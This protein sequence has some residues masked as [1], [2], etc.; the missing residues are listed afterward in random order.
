MIDLGAIRRAVD[1]DAPAHGNIR[2]PIHDDRRPSLSLAL[3]GDGRLLVHCKSGCE[4][5]AVFDAVR[6][7][8][9]HLL[10]GTARMGSGR[11]AETAYTYKDAKGNPLARVIRKDSPDGSKTFR[12]QT[13]DGNG[14]W[15]WKGPQGATP[16]FGLDR[17][18]R[19]TDAIVVLCEGEKSAEAAQRRLG[20]GF[21][22]MSWMGG[23]G[24]VARADL[25]PLRGRD[26]I[27]WP[28]NDPPGIAA[29]G[30]LCARLPGLARTVKVAR[31]GDLPPKAD[32][33][34]VAWT[35][36]DLLA[37]LEEPRVAE[38][39]AH[40]IASHADADRAARS[41]LDDFA[42]F[43][44][45]HQYIHVPT[46]ALW[47]A[48]SV[49]N[50]VDWPSVNGKR[51]RPSDYLDKHRPVHQMTWAPGRQQVVENEIVRAGGWT[52]HEGARVFN[53]YSP[54]TMVSGNPAGAD[55]WRAH[56]HAIYPDDAEHIER[57]LAHR[58]QR[59]Q[60]KI[61]HALVLGGGQGIGKDTLLEPAKRGVGPWNWSEVS[62]CQIVGQFNGFAASVILRINEARDLG[63]VDRFS[64][65]DKSKV[66]I[67]AP[68]DVLMVNRKHV[69][70]YPVENVTAVIIT[71]NHRHD[72]LYLP[73]D[74]RRHYVAWSEARKESF[75]AAHFDELWRWLNHGGDADVVAYLRAL[76][77]SGFNPKAPPAKTNAFWGIVQAGEA[78]EDS[79]LRTILDM[80]GCPL[81]VTLGQVADAA[82][83]DSA[84]RQDM[85]DRRARR[86]LP[87]RMERAGYLPVRNA[88]A[89]D[90]L[91]RIRG[92]RQVVYGRSRAT[93]RER[94]AAAAELAIGQ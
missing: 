78:P 35:A 18:A 4:Q 92:K 42:A 23:A 57:Y 75:D 6:Q 26:V 53:T 73:A 21:V 50:A 84:V 43:L 68:P 39:A 2:C 81:A 70:E 85:N 56:L 80:L 11:A 63:D 38:P 69:Q 48:A 7:R 46:H 31:V 14:G 93:E 94:Q 65:Y 12:Q 17:L 27:V 45:S 19:D 59:P 76:D 41:R 24:A 54:P 37:R 22:A 61:N 71:T 34:D 86:Q 79:E 33:A 5:R 67:A 40:D 77:L 52:K 16:L 87:H 29:A 47:P 1:P 90:G 64:F 32:A 28:D 91:F 83:L 10:N 66:Y 44:P 88:N 60:E 8:A 9:G 25:E 30:N 20:K 3:G 72:G 49:N 36:D 62:P 82:P 74:D 58:L 55:R 15:R 13:P 51:M 89:D